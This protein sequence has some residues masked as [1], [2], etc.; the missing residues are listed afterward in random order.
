MH[1][2]ENEVRKKLLCFQES[3]TFAK[4]NV[5]ERILVIRMMKFRQQEKASPEEATIQ[6]WKTLQ[7]FNNLFR[8]TE[9]NITAF[10]HNSASE[11]LFLGISFGFY[12]IGLHIW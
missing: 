6:T 8:I 5:Y 11:G 1:K 4:Q 12:R 9:W 2:D 10:M 3:V 7:Q